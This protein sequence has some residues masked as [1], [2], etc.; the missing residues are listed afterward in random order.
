MMR[1]GSKIEKF[2]DTFLDYIPEPSIGPLNYKNG[3]ARSFYNNRPEVSPIYALLKVTD[4]CSSNCSYCAHA[5]KLVDSSEVNLETLKKVIDQFAEA[6]VISVNITGGEPLMRDDISELSGYIK[7]CGLFPILLTNGILLRKRIKEIA[8][9]ELGMVII[10]VDSV[11]PENYKKARGVDIHPVLDGIDALLELGNDAPV[12]TVTSVITRHN[13][14]DLE[15]TLSY[16]SDRNIGVELCPY[17]HNGRWED[18]QLSPLSPSDYLQL[19]QKLKSLKDSSSSLINSHQ[20]LDNFV[21]FTFN[22]RSVPDNFRCYSGFTTIYIDSK[23]NV[24]SC[25]SQGLPTAG[26]LHDERLVDLL[27][28]SKMKKMRSKIKKMQCERCWLLCTAE[29]SLKWQ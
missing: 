5:G 1:E 9:A 19:V 13:L 21:N 2:P 25:W 24:R 23:L 18:D 6:G 7:K 17:H 28:N 22:R 14:N 12:I 20:Y 29:I 8:S 10:S 27:N 4:R 11:D 16:F 3:L 15:Q 26:N